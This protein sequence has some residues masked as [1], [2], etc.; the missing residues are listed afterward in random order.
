[1]PEQSA[2]L[3]FN[4]SNIS[5]YP[6]IFFLRRFFSMVISGLKKCDVKFIIA[7]IFFSGLEAL[8]L[9]KF[10]PRTSGRHSKQGDQG[11]EAGGLP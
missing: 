10:I 1:V 11:F 9:G 2:T 7:I 5:E 3:T 4:G 8:C 6:Y